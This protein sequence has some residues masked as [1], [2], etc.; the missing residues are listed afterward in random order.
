MQGQIKGI[1]NL[2]RFNLVVVSIFL[3]VASAIS[4][5]CSI[6]SIEDIYKEGG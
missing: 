1:V 3:L 4:S 2:G 6:N 5:D